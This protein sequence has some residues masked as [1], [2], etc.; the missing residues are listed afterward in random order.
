MTAT[1]VGP[2]KR[3]LHVC[4]AVIVLVASLTLAGA[5]G[6]AAGSRLHGEPPATNHVLSHDGSKMIVLR[7]RERRRY[8]DVIDTRSGESR[9]LL[10]RSFV[11][12][13][14]GEDSDT[15]YASA[16]G[17]EIHRL[18]FAAGA[19]TVTP[20]AL[21]GAQGI[22][23]GGSPRVVLFPTSL[24]PNS[25]TRTLLARHGE[26][27]YR[28]TLDPAED[29]SKIGARCE[30]ADADAR[31]AGNWLIATDGQIAA[32]TVAAPSG[33]LV[34]QARTEDGAW[35]PVF[36]YTPGYTRLTTLGGVQ[37]DNTV[38]ALSSRDRNHTALVRLDI[39]TGREEVFYEHGHVEVDSASVMFG[40]AGVGMPLLAN[41]FPGYQEVVHF[42]PR[43]E[44]GYATLRERLGEPLRIDFRSADPGLRF[45]VVEVQSPEFYRR[46]YLLDLEAKTARELSAAALA[47]YDRPAAASR[48]VSFP[49]SDGLTLHG[50]LTAPRRP[51][52]AGPPPAVLMLHGGPWERDLWP[53]P[54][55]VRFL[56]SRGYAVLQLNYRGSTGYGSDFLEAGTGAL[57]GRLQRDVL[58][59][60]RW[61]IAEGH[62][63]EGRIALFGGSFGGLLTL[64]TLARHPE[65][66]RAGIAINP[67]TDTV[68][69]WRREWRR[70]DARALW[71]TF[72]A[73]R[74]LPVAALA[75]VSPVNNV[76][77][78]DAPVMLLA[79]LQDRRVPPEHS[80]ELFDLLR[81]AGKPA[82]LVEYRGS[83]H[84]IW[85]GDAESRDHIA[86]SIAEF[87][88]RHL[89]AERQ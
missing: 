46:W 31:H 70:D 37:R 34:F 12:M 38:W 45:A 72:L 1:K 14:W 11:T 59:A 20:I 42:E 3:D 29:G 84:N 32:R 48:P 73:S 5:S 76:R 56:G 63:E 54:S 82:E 68:A 81:A 53:A 8:Y 89:A 23:Q 50:Y 77:N 7:K 35:R 51:A 83:G 10:E 47:G 85:S 33:E 4:A 40:E 18:S 24:F 28:C 57:S 88:D 2:V 80:F 44:A 65:A 41:L 60:A 87:L 13:T 62:V 86:G 79:G 19:T 17:G 15:A 69:F 52:D 58:D 71:R 67:I 75:R 16:R 9:G 64:A 30:V 55:T 78:I 39:A 25:L 66:F 74:D 22:P 61:A 43:L 21:G 36:R 27:L 49:A 26:R 6:A